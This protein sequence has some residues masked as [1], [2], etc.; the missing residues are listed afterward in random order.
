[1]SEPFQPIDCEQMEL[2]NLFPAS[3]PFTKDGL[4]PTPTSDATLR[5][6]RYAQG[7][8]GLGYS[9]STSSVAVFPARTSAMRARVPALMASAAGYG[10]NMPVSLARLDPAQLS[11]KTSLLSSQDAMTMKHPLTAAYVAGLI[12]GE[13]CLWVQNKSGRWFTPRCDVGMSE[14]ARPVLE[15]LHRRYGGSLGSHRKATDKWEA[16]LR[17]AIGGKACQAMLADVLP[18]LVLKKEQAML[19]LSLTNED[20]AI[21]KALVS[22]LNRKGPSVTLEAGW[23]ARHVAGRWLTPQRDLVSAHGWE[24]FSSTWP[25]SGTM[26]SGIAYRLPPLV[27]LT[28][29]TACGLWPTPNAGDGIAGASNLPHRRQV[30]LPRTVALWPTPKA[31]DAERG[32]RGDLLAWVRGYE[33]KHWPTPTADHYSGLQSHGQNAILGSLNPTWVEWLMGF[34][35][36]WT[37]LGRSATPSSRRFPN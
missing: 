21:I 32:G 14:K 18:F 12:D 23:F 4:W 34:P 11:S 26:R 22:E 33:N 6:R 7:G 9:V 36:G 13:G 31:A 37:D 15:K 19:L 10:A 2:F 29:G 8:K 17:W 30:S 25:R 5:K 16:A 1:M 27:P 35:C 3:S 20:G 28:G 24:E